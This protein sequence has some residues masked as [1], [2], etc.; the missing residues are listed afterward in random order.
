MANGIQPYAIFS[1]R[2]TVRE[3]NIETLSGRSILASKNSPYSGQLG[4]GMNWRL[5]YGS[6]FAEFEGSSDEDA[7]WRLHAGVR[8]G[9]FQGGVKKPKD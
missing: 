2:Q 7:R 8:F 5:R 1:V 6:L 9:L 4:L 3:T